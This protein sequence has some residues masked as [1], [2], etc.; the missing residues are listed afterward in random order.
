M[1]NPYKDVK[2]GTDQHIASF[3]HR[4]LYNDATFQAAYERGFR[5]F[6]SS[7][8]YPSAPWYPLSSRYNNVPSDV[9]GAPNAEHHNM[10]L[11]G[12]LN[13]DLHMNG[14]G[15]TWKS[16]NYKNY[17]PVGVSDTWEYAVDN[18]LANLQFPTG[19]GVTINHPVWSNLSVY[20]VMRILDYD[21]RV[22]GIEIFNESC[23]IDKD[24]GPKGWALDYWDTILKTGRRAWGFCVEDWAYRGRN[25]LLVDEFT[26]RKCLEA[27]RN[28][29]FYGKINNTD[30]RFESISL[31]SDNTTLT[32]KTNNA[33]SIKFVVN[34]VAT[35]YRA[36]EAKHVL[37]NAATYVRVEAHT[38]SDSIFSNPIMFD[39][40]TKK[41]QNVLLWY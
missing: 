6:P 41:R 31:A 20:D 40:R 9:L 5:H 10:I 37:P 23:E 30:L 24:R 36:S 7:N 4:H 2:W 11:N 21:E 27:Y 35:E 39:R 13:S 14:L 32:V 16:G 8:Y 12:K 15:S 28:G 34:G 38:D 26:E 29:N 25:I 33:T 19:G 1:I 22:L 3:S 17:D 18:I